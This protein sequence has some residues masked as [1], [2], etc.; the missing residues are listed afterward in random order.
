MCDHVYCRPF[1]VPL[2]L[3]YCKAIL[4]EWMNMNVLIHLNSCPVYLVGYTPHKYVFMYRERRAMRHDTPT[5]MPRG[6]KKNKKTKLSRPSMQEDYYTYC[7]ICRDL[8]YY[9]LPVL[10]YLRK[11]NE[12]QQFKVGRK[13]IVLL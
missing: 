5:I 9:M 10:S 3:L 1:F 11:T 8:C 4:M 7:R 13:Q 12:E 2:V 6:R